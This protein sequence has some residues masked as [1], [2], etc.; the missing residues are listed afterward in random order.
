MSLERGLTPSQ[1]NP[2]PVLAGSVSPALTLSS[3]EV[4]LERPRV[5]TAWVL[6]GLTLTALYVPSVAGDHTDVYEL[7]LGGEVVDVFELVYPSGDVAPR[8][9]AHQYQPGFIVYDTTSLALHGLTGDESGP[10]SWRLRW[11]GNVAYL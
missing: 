9:V 8:V 10:T 1:R 6:G 7:K 5:G 11:S 2:V 3:F 4:Q